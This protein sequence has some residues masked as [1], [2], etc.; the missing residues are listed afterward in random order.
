MSRRTVHI[1]I[2]TANPGK[3]REIEAVLEEP[4]APGALGEAVQ[5]R[6]HTLAD[7]PEPIEEPDENGATFL[8]NA[9]LKARYYSRA[10]GL[11]TLADDS[12]LEV[13]ALGNEPGVRSAR[14]AEAPQGASRDQRDR[15]NNRK[16]IECLLGVPPERRIARYRC[17]LALADGDRI[18]ATTEGTLEGRIID[19][20]RGSGGFGYDPHFLLPEL[21]RTTAELSAEHKNRIS[22]RGVA[23]RALRKKLA[24]L[25]GEF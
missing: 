1:L 2:A 4:A 9:V 21:G 22:H 15:A 11:W 12:G 3:A 10:S 23:L 14:F 25:L 19:E 20:P 13:D 16:L 6:W 7:W 17:V 8:E 24:D 18:L 5:V